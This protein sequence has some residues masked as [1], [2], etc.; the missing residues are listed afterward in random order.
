MDVE[1]LTSN[2]GE[3]RWFDSSEVESLNMPHSAKYMILHYIKTGQYTDCLY[4]G[5]TTENSVEFTE[6]REF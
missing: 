3:L 4:G 2:E 1:T 6:L 5:I